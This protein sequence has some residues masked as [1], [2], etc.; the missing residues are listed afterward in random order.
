MAFAGKWCA[1]KMQQIRLWHRVRQVQEQQDRKGDEKMLSPVI[2]SRNPWSIFDELESL[3]ENVNSAFEGE[4]PAMAGRRGLLLRRGST[5]PLMNVWSS[6]DGLVIDAEIPGIDPKDVEIAVKGDEL[7]VSGKMNTAVAAEGETFY[8][9]ER[10]S[11]AFVRRLQLPFKAA[12]G[13][14]KANCRN[15]VLRLTV[16]RSED[17]KPK[18]IAVEAE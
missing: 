1:C 11:G 7:T 3:R 16:P 8:R 6:P 12:A 17:E 5:Y 10:P 13:A 15:G 9:R 14:V 18:K 2:W 4:S